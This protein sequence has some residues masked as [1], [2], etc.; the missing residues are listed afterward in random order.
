M[1]TDNLIYVILAA[2]VVVNWARWIVLV[3]RHKRSIA[4]AV[5]IGFL[6]T[7]T[8]AFLS[9]LLTSWLFEAF[10]ASF[11]KRSESFRYLSDAVATLFSCALV[12]V[13]THFILKKRNAA[14]LKFKSDEIDDIGITSDA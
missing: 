3:R 10:L 7:L 14:Y 4:R 12:F 8:L 13:P 2:T 6:V 1:N 11:A 9:I 5:V